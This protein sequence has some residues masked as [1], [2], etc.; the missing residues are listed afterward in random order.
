MKKVQLKELD[1]SCQQLLQKAWEVREKAY[2]PYSNYKVGASLLTTKGNIYSGCNVESISFTLTTHAEI[3]AIDTM[4]ASGEREIAAFCVCVDDTSAWP[5]CGI[6]R[7]KLIE[8]AE[9]RSIP[10]LA[11]NR[12][13]IRE[14]TLNELVPDFFFPKEL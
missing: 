12:E 13:E 2:C 9:N 11:C 7:Q 6:C 14:Y 1:Q 4:V 10:I 3:N 8:F 5:P